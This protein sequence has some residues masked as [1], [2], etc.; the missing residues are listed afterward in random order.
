[1]SEEQKALAKP[2]PAAAAVTVGRQGVMLNSLEELLRFAKMC[3]D[4]GCA[5]KGMSTPAQAALAIQAG[6]E[7]GLGPLGGLQA[8]VVINGVLSWRGW[9]AVGM[10]QNSGVCVPGSFRSWVEGEGD[11]AVGY[12]RAQ[13]RGYDQPFVRSFSAQDAKKAGLWLKDGPWKTR[14]TNMLE[15][16]AIGDM[17]RFHFGDVLGG[18]PIAEDVEAG[19]IGE[20]RPVRE[21]AEPRPAPPATVRDPILEQLGAVPAL[22]APP[23]PVV[24]LDP[25]LVEVIAQQVDEM[26]TAE[27]HP[28]TP[29]EWKKSG[30]PPAAQPEP[31]KPKAEMVPA[32]RRQATK[33]TKAAGS[34][35]GGGTCPRCEHALNVMGGCDVCGHPGPDIR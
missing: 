31:A 21:A 3:V 23:E 20:V 1:M 2:A 11:A 28:S 13:R 7:R 34:G 29:E 16:R 30:P 33:P 35:P 10:I 9:A 8:A 18:F 5:P 4:G 6:M 15:W 17:A 14:P 25:A 27:A 32:R 22:P 19:G 26:F 24:E 12:C